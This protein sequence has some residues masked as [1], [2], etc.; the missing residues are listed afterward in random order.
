MR[1]R[2]PVA[3]AAIA[4]LAALA[5]A[6]PALAEDERNRF[7]IQLVSVDSS[8]SL[9]EAGLAAEVDRGEGLRL[10]WERRWKE[11]FGLEIGAAFSSHETSAFLGGVD[12]GTG[13]LRMVP[14][15]AAFNFHPWPER[16]L[17]LFVGAGVA[18]VDYN[19]VAFELPGAPPSEVSAKSEL[20][21][22]VQ[23]GFELPIAASYDLS[24]ALQYLGAEAELELP[25][26][27]VLPIE[28]LTI[29]FGLAIRY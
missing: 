5:V 14:I 6:L 15:S 7:R 10:A 24:L 23:A 13:K 12:L 17:D 18:L 29:A 26:S 27:P 25:G 11:R 4:A 28:P 22:L 19:D 1:S 16:K 2:R 3:T 8:G 21:W 20:T 9:D